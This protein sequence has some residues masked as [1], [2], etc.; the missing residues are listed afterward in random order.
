M[1]ELTGI[2]KTYKRPRGESVEAVIDVSLHIERA[3]FVA[4]VGESGSGKSTLMNILGLLDLP[5]QGRYLLGGQ[6]MTTLDPNRQAEMRNRRIGFVFQS[7]HLLPRT[8]ALENVELP[9]LYSDR[10]SIKDLSR[11]ALEGVNLADRIHYRPSEL[12]GGQQ[13]RVAIARALVNEPDLL[14]A[15]EPTGNLDR[16]SAMEILSIF[17]SL[18]RAGR[19]IVL[20]THDQEIA[21]Y[22]D[23]IVRLERG[24]MIADTRVVGAGV[25]ARTAQ[26]A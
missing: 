14:L 11:K 9:L 13:Q 1:I 16:Q 4:I 19:T 23:R 24:R 12:S 17:L 5:T 20:I 8:T 22:A 10:K 21:S 15:D 6:D 2:C 25:E 3:E 7:F 26:G 18:N